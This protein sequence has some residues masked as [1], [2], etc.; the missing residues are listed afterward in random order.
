MK[1]NKWKILVIAVFVIFIGMQ[2]FSPSRTNPPIDESK[3]LQ[4]S[5]NVPP[6]VSEILSSSC[7]DCHSNETKWVWYTHVA[8]V[9]FFTGNHVTE[10]RHEL[11][12]S[13]WGNYT[14]KKKGRRLEQIC[15]LAEKKEM[16]LS[17]YIWLHSD[18]KLSDE[19]IK[20]LCDWSKAEAAK[21]PKS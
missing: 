5:V 9:S 20:K 4:A 15:E 11:N 3:T 21:I 10:G 8:P 13:E 6:D 16:P 12:F 14:D 18:A 17:S 7:N 2:F 1:K 19:D